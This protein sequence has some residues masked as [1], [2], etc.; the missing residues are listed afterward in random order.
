MDEAYRQ[1]IRDAI[2]ISKGSY[3]E[4]LSSCKPNRECA[5]KQAADYIREQ[6]QALLDGTKTLKE[7]L[8]PHGINS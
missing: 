3:K 4:Y 2:E 6:L 7:I 8:D 5:H 1:A